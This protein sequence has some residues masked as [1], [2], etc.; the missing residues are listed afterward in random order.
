MSKMLT[1]LEGKKIRFT[2]H[3]IRHSAI[4]NLTEAT[5]YKCPVKRVA[6]DIKA[7]SKLA[8][9]ASTDMTEYYKKDKGM[10]TL[11]QEF[12]IVINQ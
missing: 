8:S 12:N 1:L 11:E 6:Y 10:K 5:H 3:D 2:P 4:E 9:H 7:V